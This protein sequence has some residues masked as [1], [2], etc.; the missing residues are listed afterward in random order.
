MPDPSVH[1]YAALAAKVLGP[2]VSG[3]VEANFLSWQALAKGIGLGIGA[4]MPIGPVNVQIARRVLRAGFWSGV[5]LGCGAVTVD[6]AYALLSAFSFTR[7]LTAKW[8]VLPVAAFGVVLLAYLG[9]QCLRAARRAWREDPVGADGLPAADDGPEG[10]SAGARED[11]AG[12]AGPSPAAPSPSAGPQPGTP[13]RT[14][15]DY[16][17]G[18]L[19]TLLNPM[20][21]IF[22]F[23]VVPAMGAG[24]GAGD[25]GRGDGGMSKA[26][27]DN[28]PMMATGVF[29]G[30]LAWVFSFSTL[31]A[32]AGRGARGRE[33]RRRKWLAAADA[34][35]GASLIGFAGAALWRA[36]AAL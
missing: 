3:Q 25:G 9:V 28:L 1:P 15:R 12:A 36:A 20:T 35:G 4:A 33:D 23:S 34:V 8:V 6:V 11:S 5:A 32:V 29:I 2:V 10:G 27:A 16:L 19:M 24:G 22:W 17:T 13:N 7:V 31:L 21:L 26:V 18:L 30:T 14:S